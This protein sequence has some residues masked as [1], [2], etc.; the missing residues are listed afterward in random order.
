MKKVLFF[1]AAALL[2]PIRTVH[3]AD[4]PELREGLWSVHTQ[5]I[6][7][8]GN[9]KSE[10]SSTICRSHAYDEHVRSLAKDRKGCTAN[11]SFEGGKQTMES[12]CVVAGTTIDTK[13]T[14][15]FQGDT[16]ARS[17]TRTTYS[18]AFGGVSDSTM[19]MDQKYM[20]SCPAGVQPG[21]LTSADGK[22]RHLWK[23]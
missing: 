3:S 12:H 13:G 4:P 22:V 15:V 23:Q 9:K 21:D 11:G 8:P 17:E 7:N 6:D 1:S 10:S 20:G 16:S 19:T 2:L 14:S 5:T 18:P